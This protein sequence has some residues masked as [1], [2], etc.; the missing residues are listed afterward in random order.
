MK[1]FTSDQWSSFF[2]NKQE[3]GMGYFTGDITLHDGR[4][5][6]DAIF[7]E[8]K[9]TKIRGLKDIPF[10]TQDIADIHLTVRRWNWDE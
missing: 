5:F 6:K 10:E 7:V 4:K 3:S 1:A 2:D 8:G 9:I